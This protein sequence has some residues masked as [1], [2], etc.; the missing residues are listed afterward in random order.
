[1]LRS[2]RPGFRLTVVGKAPTPEMLRFAREDPRIRF[3][4]EADDIR[5]L[6]RASAVFACPMHEGGGTRMKILD[7]MAQG[8]P[9]VATRMAVE[10]IDVVDGETGLLPD[11]PSVFV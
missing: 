9:I 2:R 4:G 8:V 3:V 11:E 5:P 10:G 6:V 1:L 7:A